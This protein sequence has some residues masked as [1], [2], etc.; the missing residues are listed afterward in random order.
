MVWL[1][2]LGQLKKSTSSGLE[3]ATFQLLAQCLNQL[4]YRVP[5]YYYNMETIYNLATE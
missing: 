3:P 5:R 1:E 4:H 2:G